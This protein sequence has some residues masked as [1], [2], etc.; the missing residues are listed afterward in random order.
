MADVMVSSTTDDQAA[1]NL[2]AGLPAEGVQEQE[3][4]GEKEILTTTQQAQETQEV[5]EEVEGEEGGEEEEHRPLPKSK[6][7]KRI[8]K[9]TARNY[10]LEETNNELK[11]RLERLERAAAGN[12][13]AAPPVIGTGFTKPK[14]KEADFEKYEDFIDSLTDWKVE[15]LDFDKQQVQVKA[16]QEQQ[17]AR[18]KQTF[19]AYNK[20]VSDFR[21][22]HDDYDEVVGREDLQLPM[23]IMNAIVS[24]RDKGPEVAYQIAQNDE[25]CTHLSQIAVDHGDAMALTEF[26]RWLASTEAPVQQNEGEEEEE[27]EAP[28]PVAVRS[29]APK[30]IRPVGNSSTRSQLQMDE[31]PFRDYRRLRDEQEKARHRR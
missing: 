9:L 27:Q 6:V 23:S 7:Q 28:Q 14:P 21:A 13:D 19:S 12:Q 8:D 4:P 16:Q 20:A 2:A 18:Q 1:V 11:E 5:E 26:G 31:L 15:K 24:M 30:P 25:L 3:Q 17:A 22:E 29:R 10:S